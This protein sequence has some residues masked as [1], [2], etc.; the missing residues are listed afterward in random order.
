MVELMTATDM[1][2][3]IVRNV[4]GRLTMILKQEKESLLDYASVTNPF[5][6]SARMMQ[7]LFTDITA[8]YVIFVLNFSTK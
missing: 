8:G 3:I 6:N 7:I 5:K 2:Y 1:R 4:N